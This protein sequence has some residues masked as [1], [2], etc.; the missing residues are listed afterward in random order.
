MASRSERTSAR[1]R[2]GAV[3][4]LVGLATV[5]GAASAAATPT[6]VTA[7]RAYGVD[8]Y[9]TA[10]TLEDPARD[11]AY[12]VTGANYADG[13]TAGAV[14]GHRGSNI[15]LTPREQL[16]DDVRAVIGYYRKVVVVGSEAAVGPDVLTW[17][18]Q[19]TRAELSRVGGAD[20][21][22]TA[23]KLSAAS[24]APG[25][26]DVVI[27]T[28]TDYADALAGSAAAA[29]V[30]SPVLVV[31]P[32]HIPDSV[33]AELARLAPQRITV[34][35]G[36]QSVSAAVAGDLAQYTSGQVRRLSGADRYETAVA[37]SEAYFPA[38]A[39]WVELASGSAWP[40]AIAAG[41]SAGRRS[42][43]V[44]LTPQHCLPQR[45]NLEIERLS[46]DQ[47]QA[48]GGN[49]SYSEVAAKR[50]SCGAGEKKYLDEFAQPEGNAT[51]VQSHATIGGVFYPRT[52]AFS[53]Y[54][55]TST[56]DI[57]NAEYRVWNIGTGHSRFTAVAGV[58][59][60]VTSGLTARV[61]VFGDERLLGGYDVA[62]G[63]PASIDVDVRGVRNLKLVTTSSGRTS[64]EDE[65]DHVV[66]FGDS[67]VR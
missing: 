26:A 45:V 13:V 31:E 37:A 32:G 53:T 20:R 3:A 38:G 58:A 22:E 42:S 50:T 9:A 24:F 39:P 29:S 7:H 8:R 44:L 48:V 63:Q 1:R 60:G 23:A 64:S 33:R 15:F 41:A 62:A 43:P 17:L 11:T 66:Y 5:A 40:D 10:A 2:T 21:Y 34:L 19:N 27:A 16:T 49:G 28:G 4:A 51:Y 67:A 25:V 46:P 55:P 36:E 47:I 30:D 14:A 61:E 12:V 56:T 65:T 35:G 52:A 6:P 54:V 18:R 57:R 59:D